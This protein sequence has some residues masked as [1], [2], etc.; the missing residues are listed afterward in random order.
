MAIYIIA[1]SYKYLCKLLYLMIKINT[2]FLNCSMNEC[3]FRITIY[4]VHI[5]IANN[6]ASKEY[7]T[8]Y[9]FHVQAAVPIY[10]HTTN[11]NFN[12]PDS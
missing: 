10:S 2:M 12:K 9:V 1:Y 7:S 5:Y 11:L 8:R 3:L 6:V 4:F